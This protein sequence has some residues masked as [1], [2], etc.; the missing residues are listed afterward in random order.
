MDGGIYLAYPIDQRGPETS[1]RLFEAIEQLKTDAITNRVAKWV[2]DPG[3][4]FRVNPHAEPDD[5]LARINRV[6]AESAAA[7]VAFLP[8]GVASIG[9]PVE[10]DRAVSDGKHVVV[11]SDIRA[12][13]V[14]TYPPSTVTRYHSW[15]A[16]AVADAVAWLDR[17]GTG[18]EAPGA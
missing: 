2:F 17:Q 1:A 14:L 15:D 5:T 16:D 9:V 10:I 3:E 6:A 11:F 13:W 8:A 12:S 7:V 4:G 18:L